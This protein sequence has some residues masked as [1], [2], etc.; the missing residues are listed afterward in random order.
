MTRRL[1]PKSPRGLD[2]SRLYRACLFCLFLCSLRSLLF[3]SHLVSSRL[4]SSRLLSSHPVSFL[5]TSSRS[6]V[7]SNFYEHLLP[8][9]L[10]IA[11][12]AVTPRPAL[13]PGTDRVSTEP[14]RVPLSFLSFLSSSLLAHFFA[15]LFLASSYPS[16]LPRLSILLNCLGISLSI[17][18]VFEREGENSQGN[19]VIA[20]RFISVD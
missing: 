3:S 12:L 13:P 18:A 10:V 6:F 14:S 15:Y 11:S 4:V 2:R 9:S 5:K 17:D 19:S 16:I 8:R 20:S 1:G 7:R